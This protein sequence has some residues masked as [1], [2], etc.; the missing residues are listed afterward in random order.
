VD[1][2]DQ[3][4]VQNPECSDRMLSSTRADA[5]NDKINNR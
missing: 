1:T 5:Q 4:R 2:A 3:K